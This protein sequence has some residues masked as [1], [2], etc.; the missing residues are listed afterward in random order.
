MGAADGTTCVDIVCGGITFGMESGAGTGSTDC[1]IVVGERGAKE[2]GTPGL[3]AGS[4]L[5]TGAALLKVP[6]PSCSNS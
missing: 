6:M 5:E 4:G 3:C 1:E 2:G